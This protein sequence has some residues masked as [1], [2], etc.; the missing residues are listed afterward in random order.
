MN[1]EG[2]HT[3]SDGAE[4]ADDPVAVYQR[5]NR[6]TTTEAVVKAIS[7]VLD[8][9]ETE[10]EPIYTVINPD[11]LD[12]LFGPREDGTSLDGDGYVTFGYDDHR[13]RVVSDGTVVVY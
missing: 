7:R 3:V 8:V 9:A 2:E 6:E 4:S 12:S 10:L 1:I 13:V 11:A 5:S